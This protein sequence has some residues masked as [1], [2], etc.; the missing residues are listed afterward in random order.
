MPTD[1]ASMAPGTR[2]PHR[3]LGQEQADLCKPKALCMQGT[4]VAGHSL[5]QPLAQDGRGTPVNH[6][7][8]QT[9]CLSE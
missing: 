5:A 2:Q 9:W 8:L 6:L 7:T 4:T 3:A 1:E